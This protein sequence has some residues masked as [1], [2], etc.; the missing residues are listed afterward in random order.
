MVLAIHRSSF[1]CSF[2]FFCSFLL[3]SQTQVQSFKKGVLKSATQD[4]IVNA[5]K[6]TQFTYAKINCALK[7]SSSDSPILEN[8]MLTILAS[9]ASSSSTK[10]FECPHRK[11][12]SIIAYN[13]LI[14]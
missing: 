10:L 12:D 3:N 2:S 8:L 6:K 13:D 5:H 9:N 7:D 11:N 1:L 14:I 4:S